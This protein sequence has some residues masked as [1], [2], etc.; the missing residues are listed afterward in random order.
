[1]NDNISNKTVKPENPL[2]KTDFKFEGLSFES[3]SDFEVGIEGGIY[4]G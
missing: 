1:M 3:N 2:V 4:E